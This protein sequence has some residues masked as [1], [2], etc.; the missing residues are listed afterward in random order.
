M[1]LLATS[2]AHAQ[3]GTAFT[4]QGRV[5]QSGTAVNGPVDFEFQVYD[6][7]TAGTSVGG[8]IT[9]TDVPLTDGL[10]TTSLDFGAGVFA[11]NRRWLEIRLSP[12]F[13]TVAY[14]ILLPRQ[15]LTPTPY[16]FFA[17]IAALANNASALGG[18]PPSGYALTG[19]THAAGTITGIPAPA[20]VFGVGSGSGLTGDAVN[21]SYDSTAHDLNLTGVYRI[22]GGA[23]MRVV[24]AL[25]NTFAGLAGNATVT[26]AGN[27][28]L[29]E[30][31]L[32]AANNVSDNTAIGYRALASA[33]ADTAGV[34]SAIFGD[35]N[36]AIGK[37]ALEANTFGFANVAVGTNALAANLTGFLNTAVGAGALALG[38]GGGNTIVGANAMTVVTAANDNTAVGSNALRLNTASGNIAIGANAL[39]TNTSGGN[40]T[41][42]GNGALRTNA[43]GVGNTAV[44][45][46]ALSL[47]TGNDNTALG[48]SA[49]QR[50]TGI[51]NTAVGA[52]SLENGSTG[53]GNTAVGAY[54]LDAASSG[55]NNTAVGSSALDS[56]TTASNNTA[57]GAG[58][59][60]DVTIGTANIGIGLDAGGQITIGSNNIMIGGG[61]APSLGDNNNIMIGHPGNP[62]ES[63]R[64][65][66][67]S[68]G[69]HL[70]T[71]IAGIF[72]T[73]IL[74]P[75]Q[76][77]LINGN[78]QLGTSIA[79]S[80]AFK[81]D[82]RDMGTDADKLLGLRPVTFRYRE[83]IAP[84]GDSRLPQ[85]GLIA[86]EVALVNPD[87]VVRDKNG[88]TVGVRYDQIN[89]ALLGLAQRQQAKIELMNDEMRALA[90]RLERIEAKQ[91]P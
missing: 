13:P 32:G 84:E 38:T 47:S 34:P 21:F 7:A 49:L 52:H 25:D 64:I 80:K 76:T 87:W 72:N 45:Q 43:T 39:T 59:M 69:T 53:V 46:A 28:A 55:S 85:F 67:G 35:F 4:Y 1:A 6:D 91:A 11:G 48:V 40:N 83:D 12:N 75:V 17:P 19:H 22:G 2:S 36:T 66:I 81:E 27:T 63:N 31:A 70:D 33:I 26:G 56:V 44:G 61:I 51:R 30:S 5:A 68:T 88:A 8:P 10:F 3:V 57:V 42:V 89:A 82:I 14:T 78:G 50:T 9:R 62:G 74:G 60:D 71:R 18:V 90:A 16:A 73:A 15:Q 54:A 29:G 23:V 65:R 86:E 37:S 79:S 20:V 77:V 58:A 41:A 24:P